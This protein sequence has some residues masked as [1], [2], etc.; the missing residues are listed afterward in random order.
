METLDSVYW[1]PLLELVYKAASVHRAFFDP[2]KMQICELLSIKTG[3]CTEDCAYCAQSSKHQTGLHLE[4]LLNVEEVERQAKQAKDRGAVRFCMGAAWPRV[5][6]GPFFDRVL[7]MVRRVYALGLEPCVTLGMLTYEEACRLK[8]AGCH[9][10]NH[11]LDTSESFYP[12]II[13]TR[14]Y[15][16][17]IETIKAV[18]KAGLHVCCGGIIG[19]GESHQDRIDLLK[20]L[21]SFTP[22][23]DSVPINALIPFQGTPLASRPRVSAWE[24]LRMVAAARIAMPSSRIRLSAGRLEMNEA[25]QALCFLAGANSIHSSG[26][27]LTASTHTSESDHALL[28]LLGLIPEEEEKDC[29]QLEPFQELN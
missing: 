10:Y 16:D 2:R 8:E 18:Q 21:A 4:K 1:L 19:L 26:K 9:S 12:S 11:N 27:L 7:E 5:R 15:Q 28:E 14:T 23:P 29:V 17:R 24:I 22:P 13:T 6:S 3:G 20:T 25:E